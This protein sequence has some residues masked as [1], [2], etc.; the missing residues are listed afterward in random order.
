MLMIIMLIIIMLTI[1]MVDHHHVDVLNNMSPH[2]QIAET[3]REVTAFILCG[4]HPSYTQH[5][6]HDDHEDDNDHDITKLAQTSM[7]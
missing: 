1:I 5:N 2:L 3:E 4:R 7:P 6:D